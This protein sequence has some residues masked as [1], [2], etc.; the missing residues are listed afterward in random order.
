M[1]RDDGRGTGRD[2]RDD[3]PGQ[4]PLHGEHR[5]RH[6]PRQRRHRERRDEAWPLLVVDV[7]AVDDLLDPAPAGV[8]D[9]R[10]PVALLLA[11]RG[12][13]DAGVCDRLLAGAHRQVDEAAHPTGHLGVH[14][15]GRIEVE[16]LGRDADL[17]VRRVEAPDRPRPS[18]AGLEVR[19][20][21]RE[22][23]ADRHDGAKS[24]HD[25]APGRISLRHRLGL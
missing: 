22:V 9:H 5:R 24:G 21:R 2:L 1:E 4:P 16:D 10:D 12:E 7:R 19:P 13:V 15:A 8:H 25:R 18:H 11:H 20:V 3:R 23:V 17:V 14:D 6:R